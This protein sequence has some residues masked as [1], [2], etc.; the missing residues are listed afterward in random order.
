MSDTKLELVEPTETLAVEFIECAEEFRDAGE[1]HAWGQLDKF[2]GDVAALVGHLRDWS[3]GRDLP[4]GWVPCNT[5]WAVVGGRV[6]GQVRLRRRLTEALLKRGGHIGYEVRPSE[7]GKG[8][9]TRTL[10]MALE[11]AKVLGLTRVLVTCDRDNAS[12]ARVIEKNGG[13]FESEVEFDGAHNRRYW[14]ELRTVGS[15][16][17]SLRSG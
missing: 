9:A 1:P 5:Y 4:D 3:A 15:R 14:I 11:K 12:S 16:D 13:V 6:V 8:Y 17:P 7:R 2:S 10:A